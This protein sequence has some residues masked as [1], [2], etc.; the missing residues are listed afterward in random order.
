MANQNSPI[1]SFQ[2]PLDRDGVFTSTASLEARDERL[3]LPVAVLLDNVRSMYN[4]GAFFRA[5][6]GAGLQK[7]CLCGITAH[8]PKKAISKTA[9][10]AEESVPWEHGW[11][12]IKM[13]VG[14]RRSGFEIAA[15]ETSLHSVNLFEWQ[16]KFPVCV[17]FGNEVEGL[18]PELLEMADTHV[19]IPMLGRK[20]SLNV[21]T[22]G[23]IVV[24]EL[25]RK[26]LLTL[27]L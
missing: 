8:P 21:A 10:G 19:R 26:Y 3:R 18:R 17:A 4:V 24:Y 12:A 5:A 6:D 9:L 23:G 22:A 27:S 13:A 7:L 1:T 15:I 2:A 11:D 20:G 25:L 14:L 16:P